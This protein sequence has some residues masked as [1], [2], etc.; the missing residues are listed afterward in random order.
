MCSPRP[1]MPSSW[2]PAI[3]W[4]KRMQRVHWMQRVM[5]VDTSGPRFSSFTDALALGEARDV[6]AEAHR[7]I[8]QL[9]LP[10]LIADR[11]VERMIDE[12]EFHGGALR[13]DRLAAT[14]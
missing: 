12:Q 2:M 3:S 9:A 5:S 10:A 1:I 6:A 8:L 11:A 4:V 7:Q 14:G 13:A